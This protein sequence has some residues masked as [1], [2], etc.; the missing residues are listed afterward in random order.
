MSKVLNQDIP[1]TD[2][3]IKPGEGLKVDTILE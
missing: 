3:A 1:L 2:G